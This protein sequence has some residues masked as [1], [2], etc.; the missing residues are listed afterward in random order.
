LKNNDGDVALN[1]FRQN[2]SIFLKKASLEKCY[3]YISLKESVSKCSE[4]RN[5]EGCYFG[6]GR[7]YIVGEMCRATNPSTAELPLL[8]VSRLSHT[9]Y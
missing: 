3:L 1:Q 4:A 8:I 7:I 6:E 9:E 5:R 2:Y